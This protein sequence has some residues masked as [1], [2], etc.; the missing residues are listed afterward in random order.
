M[1]E[2][3]LGS[4][5][6]D[7]KDQAGSARLSCAV[8]VA[9]CDRYRD[10]WTPFFTLFWRYWP[11][12]PYPVYLGA[13]CAAYEDPRVRT[14][15]AGE[16]Q[17]WSRGLKFFLEQ[18]DTQYVFL[19]LEDFFFDGP[20]PLKQFNEKMR[21]LQTL[22]G[23]M[24]RLNPN[25]PP[26]MEL[27]EFRGIGAIHQFAPYRVSAQPAIWN[28]AALVSLLRDGESPWEFERQATRR[29]QAKAHGFF[30][31]YFPAF[32]YRHVV[33]QGRWFWSAAR[34]YE[35]Q[36]IGCDFNTRPVMGA[37]VAFIK[38][39]N[40]RVRYWR[41]R[42]LAWRLNRSNPVQLTTHQRA[43]AKL[44]IAVLTNIIPPYQKPVLDRLS[45]RYEGMR[46]LVS[47]PMEANRPWKLECEGLDVVVQ[48]T[49]TLTGRWRHPRGFSEPVAV[50]LPLDTVQQ[51][52]RF[53]ADLVIS[54]E[55]GS[56]T[57][58][59]AV[60]RKIR[61]Q[62]TLIVWADVGEATE[63]GR[64]W[65]RELVRRA[66]HPNVDAFL[67]IGESGAQYLRSLGV[68][69]EKIAKVWY[70]TDLRRFGRLALSRPAPQ[71]HRLLYVGQLI[72]RKGLVP[73]VRALSEWAS[74]H[75]DR[76]VELAFAGSGPMRPVLQELPVTSNVKLTFLGSV[77]YDDLPKVY[78][79]AGILVL[80]TLADTWGVVVNEA[81][82]AGLPVLGSIYAQA[83]AEMVQD[84]ENGWVFAAGDGHQT[85]RAIDSCMNT[86][87]EKLDQMRAHARSTAA[88]LSP[89]RL[90]DTIEAAISR[91]VNHPH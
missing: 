18:I 10:L 75:A 13:N 52:K 57:L 12:C 59:A 70:A 66:L 81:M 20:F 14:L 86:A 8:L 79:S 28:R 25:P 23:T 6:F 48:K 54:S 30:G 83:V 89:E 32:S 34:H 17:S 68:K 26:D 76:L 49:L 31:T 38:L 84:G 61:R 90:A 27:R 19:L 45:R 37:F 73:F 29:S 42:V 60:Y 43:P 21:T 58:L 44:R 64:G 87:L 47:T 72:E 91:C 33:E 24:L 78:G 40:G 5:A 65:A 16:D 9:S 88:Q 11:D 56:R 22:D 71:A 50:H 7:E 82:A 1:L 35:K 80:P 77:P 63:R 67:A 51:L 39:I 41:D 69:S 53:R 46:V 2:A 85:Y 62:S 36:N 4:R 74:A 15:K 3:K 55:M